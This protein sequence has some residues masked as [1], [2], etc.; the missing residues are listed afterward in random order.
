MAK[1]LIWPI[2]THWSRRWKVW[3]VQTKSVRVKFCG[4]GELAFGFESSQ[5]KI[6]GC[7]RR[8]FRL[9]NISVHVNWG[10]WTRY[11]VWSISVFVQ[12]CWGWKRCLR[13]QTVLVVFVGVL[14]ALSD[15]NH[16][17]SCSSLWGWKRCFQDRTISLN[18]QVCGAEEGVFG[19]ESYE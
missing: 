15:L 11:R 9:L 10:W 8:C 2:L 14:K 4:G 6:S 13:I 3:L 19:F 1:T 5:Y 17:S 16:I 12:V 18:V 7:W